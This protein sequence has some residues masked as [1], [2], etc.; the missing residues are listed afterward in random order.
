MACGLCY[1]KETSLCRYGDLSFCGIDYKSCN[2]FGARWDA[3]L[4]QQI[5]KNIVNIHPR[6]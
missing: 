6:P 1:V 3:R 4:L 2:A 5:I